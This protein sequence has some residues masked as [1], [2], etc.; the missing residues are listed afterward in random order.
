MNQFAIDRRNGV[1]LVKLAGSMTR[2]SLGVLDAEVKDVIAREGS[3]A[4]IF[5][6]TDVA[7]LRIQPSTAADRGRQPSVMAGKPR[8]F[9]TADPLL[10]GMLRVYAAYRDINGEKPP[11]VVR[12]LLEAFRELSLIDPKFEPLTIGPA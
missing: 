5:D 1:L 4:A 3:M 12:L 9:V 11:M 8:V 10:F 6:F 7:A 2:E